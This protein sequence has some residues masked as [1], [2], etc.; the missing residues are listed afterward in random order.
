MAEQPRNWKRVIK[1]VAYYFLI[2]LSLLYLYTYRTSTVNRGAIMSLF[3]ICLG[4]AYLLGRS[5]KREKEAVEIAEE[6]KDWLAEMKHATIQLAMEHGGVL[7]VTDVAADLEVTLE[8]AERTLTALDDG[9][10]VTSSVTEDGVIVY[11]F[12]EVKHRQSRLQAASGPEKR[13]PRA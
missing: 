11:E 12:K 2:F 10:R 13:R 9:V 8:E 1:T 4:G 3:V 6:D 5:L 7:T